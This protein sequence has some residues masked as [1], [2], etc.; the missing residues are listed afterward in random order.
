MP[1]PEVRKE[2]LVQL[3]NVLAE[4][5]EIEAEGFGSTTVRRRDCLSGVD[6]DACFYVKSLP[7][8]PAEVRHLDTAAVP[9]DL[10]IWV[11]AADTL[12]DK[13]P[14]FAALGIREVWR[15]D[16]QNFAILQ[17]DGEAM[18][19]AAESA[20]LPGLTAE[21]LTLLVTLGQTTSRLSWLREV[22]TWA[23]DN[24]PG[25]ADA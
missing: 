5:W 23:R 12:F 6:P 21:T 20:A 10:V 11:D 8:L 2:R 1:F 3:V 4:E 16:G 9:P 17:R 25:G 13:C 22:R 7:H 15:D 14:L 24:Q 18:Q 19:P